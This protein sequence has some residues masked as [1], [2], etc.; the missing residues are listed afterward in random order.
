M[1]IGERFYIQ[2][3]SCWFRLLF[4]KF[5]LNHN[6]VEWTSP[7]TPLHLH[8]ADQTNGWKYIIDAH[9]V[10]MYKVGLTCEYCI[11]PDLKRPISIQLQFIISFKY[12]I[13]RALYSALIELDYFCTNLNWSCNKYKFRV[14]CIHNRWKWLVIVFWHCVEILHS[15]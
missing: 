1:S 12:T 14:L 4:H 13:R 6:D 10:C 2:T 5:F 7:C 3:I 9:A 11:Q 15:V 8:P